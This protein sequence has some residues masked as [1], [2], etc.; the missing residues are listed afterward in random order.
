MRLFK[1]NALLLAL[2]FSVVAEVLFI[3]AFRLF[4]EVTQFGT[5][6]NFLGWLGFWFHVLPDAYLPRSCADIL[7]FPA[8]LL[9]WWLVFLVG[10]TCIR[11]VA[12]NNNPRALKL[13]IASLSVALIATSGWLVHSQLWQNSNWRG[14]TGSL[15]GLKGYREA[16][17]DFH[18]GKRQVFVISGECPEDRFSG[19]NDGPFAVWNPCFYPSWPYPDRYA[20]EKQIE[21]YNRHMRLMYDRSLNSTNSA[22]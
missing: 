8:L 1:L 16:D 9:Q 11:G 4:G 10:I 6:L 12:R 3:V 22:N 14:E 20:T 2:I 13:I 5:P 15:A 21:S 7:C 19:T 17:K 18:A